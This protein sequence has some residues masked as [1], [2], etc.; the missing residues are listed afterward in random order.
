MNRT[1]AIFLFALIALP[2]SASAQTKGPYVSV[3]AG[4]NKMQQEDVDAGPVGGTLTPGEILTSVG[5]AVAGALGVGLGHV[6]VEFEGSY[7]A[8]KIESET[9]LAG[10]NGATGTEKKYGAMGNILFDFG[11]AKVRPYVGVGGG[12]QSVHEPAASTTSGGITVSADAQT[13]GSFAYQA[14]AGVAFPASS[15]L[16]ITLEYRYMGLAGT[17]T[18][19]G[20][21]TIPGVGTFPLE[22][23]STNDVNHSVMFGI[24]Y[25]FGG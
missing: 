20:T 15:H 25:G 5:P 14:I 23:D 21:A 11:S 16:S 3:G 22:D 1:I 19:T 10:E 24:R 8:N 13:K 9:G 2:F 12:Y 17:R 18:F 4:I 7:R 6:R